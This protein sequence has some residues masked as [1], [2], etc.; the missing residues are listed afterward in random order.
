[1]GH[2]LPEGVKGACVCTHCTHV[3]ICTWMS[4]CTHV[5]LADTSLGTWVGSGP[6]AQTAAGSL[7]RRGTCRDEKDL[8]FTLGDE[9]EQMMLSDPSGGTLRPTNQEKD[10]ELVGEFRPAQC[11]LG[12]IR[13]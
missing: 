5:K 6:T 1:M 3:F 9:E 13:D 11:P 7:G 8:G 12:E 4:V 2:D 10:P